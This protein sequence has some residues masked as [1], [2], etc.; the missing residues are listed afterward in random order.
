MSTSSTVRVSVRGKKE[1]LEQLLNQACTIL[2]S[3]QPLDELHGLPIAGLLYEIVDRLEIEDAVGAERNVFWT[4]I[5]VA[6]ALEDCYNTSKAI[7]LDEFLKHLRSRLRRP[8]KSTKVGRYTFII[9]TQISERHCQWVKGLDHRLW[10][11]TQQSIPSRI[12]IAAANEKAR[13]LYASKGIPFRQHPI[14]IQIS[15]KD[16]PLL[17]ALDEA[18]R[19]IN[20]LRVCVNMTTTAALHLESGGKWVPSYPFPPPPFLHVFDEKGALL[21]T[22]YDPAKL[23]FERLFK[24]RPLTL[25]QLNAAKSLLGNIRKLAPSVRDA[26]AR[27]LI[28]FQEGLD[29]PFRHLAF[30]AFWRVLESIWQLD[31]DERIN[32]DDVVKTVSSFFGPGSLTARSVGALLE[33]AK[34]KRNAW[35]HLSEHEGIDD[36]DCSWL[37]L[38]LH[39]LLISL[40]RQAEVDRFPNSK[41]LRSFLLHYRLDSQNLSKTEQEATSTLSAIKAIRS[42]RRL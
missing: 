26:L 14:L 9:P 3:D 10:F 11:H 16:L 36:L 27:P 12:K 28:L 19:E 15:T 7:S 25:E 35:V 8:S 32:H 31:S 24:I 42:K 21:E 41:T 33:V 1:P 23:E 29:L 34:R 17:K 6:N 13:R 22:Y 4:R 38:I 18:E 30:S 20:L 2:K 39:L 5:K 37:R 40:V